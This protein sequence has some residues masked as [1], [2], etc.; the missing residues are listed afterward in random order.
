M[1]IRILINYLEYWAGFVS[2]LSLRDL[3]APFRRAFLA[4]M[5]LCFTSKASVCMSVS[6]LCIPL[7]LAGSFEFRHQIDLAYL[8]FWIIRKCGRYYSQLLLT[9]QL[10]SGT[11]GFGSCELRFGCHN[12][13][14]SART[15]CMW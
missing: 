5:C 8:I 13:Y 10:P 1:A 11:K 4:A 3:H 14:P 12:P 9:F 15:E 6:A 7:L 2:V